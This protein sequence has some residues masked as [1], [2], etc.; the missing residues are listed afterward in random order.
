[1]LR[2]NALYKKLE[3]DKADAML[4]YVGDLMDAH[5]FEVWQREMLA[6]DEADRR[7]CIEE[8][9]EALMASQQAMAARA[10]DKVETLQARARDQ[11]AELLAAEEAREREREAERERNRERKVAVEAE[12]AQV[13][14]AVGSMREDKAAQASE[15]RRERE[16]ALEAIAREKELE[17]DLRRELIA[18]IQAM[19]RL[20]AANARLPKVIDPTARSGIGSLVEMSLAELRERLAEV[21]LEAEEEEKSRRAQFTQVRAEKEDALEA[22]MRANDRARGQREAFGGYVRGV[23]AG[24]AQEAR[25]KAN[26]AEK[27]RLEAVRAHN[28]RK[29]SETRLRALEIARGR[30]RELE[31]AAVRERTDRETA[32]RRNKDLSIAAERREMRRVDA[33][34][35]EGLQKQAL[36]DKYRRNR[37]QLLKED[38]ARRDAGVRALLENTRTGLI[39]SEQRE[40]LE[41]AA[42]LELVQAVKGSRGNKGPLEPMT[43]SRGLRTV[44]AL[45]NAV[46]DQPTTPTYST[47]A[48]DDLTPRAVA[49]A[50]RT[51]VGRARESESDLVASLAN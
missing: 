18:E 13:A 49:T 12:K 30:R 32:E 39:S 10:R 4:R 27:S 8:R 36:R 21:R 51:I 29:E 24:W 14:V 22:M 33:E 16:S 31:E 42:R 44:S 25:D 26:A 35:Q 43:L 5:E 34:E 20:S 2:E 23:R 46:E 17:L 50:G 15:L 19:T 45:P 47:I 28:D 40:S 6:M 1:V 11:R 3:R 38:Q 9:K 48:H 41:R 37:L 7:R